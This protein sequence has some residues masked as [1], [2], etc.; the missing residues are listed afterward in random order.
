VV[1]ADGFDIAGFLSNGCLFY[2]FIVTAE[3]GACKRGFRVFAKRHNLTLFY[4][5][6][7][8]LGRIFDETSVVILNLTFSPIFS[9]EAIIFETSE[10]K[11]E[12]SLG[13]TGLEMWGK[14]CAGFFDT[15]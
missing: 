3:M 7:G 9:C 8:F 1:C 6:F 13:S 4:S 15:F 2:P 12:T 14:L 11:S 10:T 5:A